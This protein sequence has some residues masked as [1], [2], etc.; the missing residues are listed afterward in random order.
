MNNE[1]PR[2]DLKTIVERNVKALKLRPSLGQGT[3]TAL[4]RSR[5]GQVACDVTDGAHHLLVD[6]GTESG[7]QN[8]GPHPGVLMRS[9]LAACF[10]GAYQL[11]AARMDVELEE[12]EVT[13]ETDYDAR[14]MYGVNDSVPAGFLAVRASV[15]IT[16]S[17]PEER[18]REMVEEADRHSPLLYDFGTALD[19]K[20]DVTITA[21]S[22]KGV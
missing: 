15:R 21:P 13:V 12:V 3:A 10:I 8:A 9:G 22:I 11:W 4:A 20:R 7:G 2:H 16:S 5:R 1:A 14:G 6:L 19:V 17:A 18:V